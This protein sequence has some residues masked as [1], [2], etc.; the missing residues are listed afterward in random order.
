M[1]EKP[2]RC[3]LVAVV[4][5][6]NVGKSSLINALLGQKVTI[7]SE[8][9][10]T[11]RNR[12]R[13]IYSDD[14]TQIVFIDT[15]GIHLPR[16]KLGEFMV[17]TARQALDEVDLICFVVEATD[18]RLRPE[19]ERILSFLRETRRPVLLIINKVDKLRKGEEFWQ[20]VEL[21]QESLP[22]GAVLPL[23]AT[24]GT[25]LRLLRE[26][27]VQFLPEGP[28]LYPDER[29]M[30]HPERFLAAEIIR[31][32]IL[33]LT[34]EEVPHSVA[35]EIEAFETPDEYPERD[36]AYIRAVVN[37]ERP[38]Q[39][40]IVIGRGGTMLKQIGSLARAGL[41]EM[42]QEK[43]FLELF[44]KVREDWRKLDRELRRF[45]Y[46]P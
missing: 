10:Q 42:L 16:H 25:N 40:G 43:V 27:I 44:V 39:K 24:A 36:V 38:G 46:R 35:V 2:Y 45:G 33:L 7:V 37:V 14:E 6:P 1:T 19:D 21:Y 12:I 31:E 11:T 34:R 17:E 5:R 32:K 30:D 20:V 13:C 41:E 28:P 4:G 9:P 22:L 18:R 15:P 23:S 3:G 26:R 8:K 29:I